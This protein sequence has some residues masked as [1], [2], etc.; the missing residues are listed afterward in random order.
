MALSISCEKN[1]SEG[2]LMED[3]WTYLNGLLPKYLK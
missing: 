2:K 3:H 1:V